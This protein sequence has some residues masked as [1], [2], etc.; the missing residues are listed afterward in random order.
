M[1]PQSAPLSSF[2]ILFHA[3]RPRSTPPL[4]FFDRPCSSRTRPLLQWRQRAS[5]DPRGSSDVGCGPRNTRARTVQAKQDAPSACFGRGTRMVSANGLFF[6]LCCSKE[7][8]PSYS[9]VSPVLHAETR[10]L[11]LQYQQFHACFSIRFS[12][13]ADPSST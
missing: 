4:S 6:P 11:R 13:I 8:V 12:G 9:V 7:R 5:G 1:R 10:T 2:A 3:H